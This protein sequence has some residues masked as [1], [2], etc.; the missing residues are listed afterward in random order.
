MSQEQIINLL[1]KHKRPMSCREIS[2]KLEMPIKTIMIN[3]K[4]LND[5]NEV[6][7]TELSLDDSKKIHNSRRRIRLYFISCLIFFFYVL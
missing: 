4:K 5:H 6:K 2:Q 3:I 7:Y 1:E